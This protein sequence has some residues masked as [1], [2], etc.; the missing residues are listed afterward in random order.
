[1][2]LLKL[3]KIIQIKFYADVFYHLINYLEANKIK[4]EEIMNELDKIKNNL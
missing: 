3:L 4:I 2:N 1:M